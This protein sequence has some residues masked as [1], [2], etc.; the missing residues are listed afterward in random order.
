MGKEPVSKISVEGYMRLIH[1]MRRTYH[2]IAESPSRL[3][4]RGGADALD[5]TPS[6]AADAEGDGGDPA[7]FAAVEV[8]AALV[9]ATAAARHSRRLL[10]GTPA[11][12]ME[13]G[14]CDQP[15]HLRPRTGGD[16]E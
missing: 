5:D 1:A 15:G 6:V 10:I 7:A 3:R 12:R 16:H 14:R 11:L 4:L 9:A 8:D 13:T 2:K